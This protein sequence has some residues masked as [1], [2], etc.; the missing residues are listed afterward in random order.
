M[1]EASASETPRLCGQ[2]L[3]AS[4]AAV[5]GVHVLVYTAEEWD[6]VSGK[7]TCQLTSREVEAVRR[8]VHD[9]GGYRAQTARSGTFC[10]S[11][12]RSACYLVQVEKQGSAPALAV[13]PEGTTHI[14]AALR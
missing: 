10:L 11:L 8:I 12:P 4:K 6:R 14:E 1:V 2:V 5:E 13:V 9:V 3:D 7:S